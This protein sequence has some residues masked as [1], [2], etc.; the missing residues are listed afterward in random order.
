[1]LM[2]SQ[3]EGVE[4][5]ETCA[6]GIGPAQSASSTISHQEECAT[7]V[8]HQGKEADQVE[9]VEWRAATLCAQG[10]GSA[11]IASFTT[12]PP[13]TSVSN[14]PHL[15]DVCCSPSIRNHQGPRQRE[16]G[17]VRHSQYKLTYLRVL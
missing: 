6:P 16:G 3:A 14:A 9:E 11:I 2:A 17:C 5:C 7:N 15:N 13:V 12:L 8:T 4:A 1:M 10:T